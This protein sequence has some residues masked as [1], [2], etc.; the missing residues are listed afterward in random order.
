MGLSA[1]ALAALVA[2]CST[3][4]PD[5]DKQLAEVDRVFIVAAASWD[6]NKDGKIACEEWKAYARELFA[7]SDVDR[8]GRLTRAEFDRMWT[9]DRTF[10]SADFRYFDANI[11]GGVDRAEL[12]DRANPAFKHLDRNSDC[13]I[14]GE[15]LSRAIALTRPPPSAPPMGKD[16]GDKGGG[17]PGGKGGGMPGG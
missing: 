11:D 10:V 1:I 12:V 17:M 3:L 8:N 5:T 16:P 7:Y 4:L 6:A 13:V 14:D 15:E 9:N 2:S